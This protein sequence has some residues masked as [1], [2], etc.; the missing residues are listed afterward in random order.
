[1]KKLT[2]ILL[3]LAVVPFVHAGELKFKGYIKP[4]PLRGDN[5]YLILN[6]SGK[7]KARIKP[8]PLWPSDSGH[9]LIID[10]NGNQTGRIRPDYIDNR[11]Y[12]IETYKE[13]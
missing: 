1:M 11:R 10:K 12:I 8:N 13:D 5:H 7:A 9:Y 4:D 3:C 6:D 2:I